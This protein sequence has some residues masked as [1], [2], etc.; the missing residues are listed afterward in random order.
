[1]RHDA[2][3]DSRQQLLMHGLA[4]WRDQYNPLRGLD[5]S[6]AVALLETQNR[7]D[8]TDLMWTYEHIEQTDP[9]LMAL[10]E[11]RLAAI[12]EMDYDIRIASEE[13]HGSAFDA[14][15][16]EDQQ[17]TL[18]AAYERIDNL[19]EA[20]VHMATATFRKLAFAQLHMEGTGRHAQLAHIECLDAW[21]FARQGRNGPFHWNPEA[22]Q[23]AALSLGD[24]LDAERDL[25]IIRE[26]PRPVDRYGLIKFLRAN[27]AEKDW[28][29]FV[30]IYGFNQTFVILPPN[31]PD[32][33]LAEY[34]A[35]AERAADG[36][37]GAV[38]HG[39]EVKFANGERGEQPFRPRLEWLQQQLILAGTGGLL[40]ML[41]A[42]GSGTLAGN[43][44]ADT[45][46][47]LARSEARQISERFQRSIDRLVL[48]LA[49]PGRPRLAYF[50]LA[51]NEE[52]AVGE[53]VDHAVK[54]ATAFPGLTMDPD[55]FA[56]KTGYRLAPALAAPAPSLMHR[57]ADASPV[58]LSGTP[59]AAPVQR[60]AQAAAEALRAS[61]LEA[62]HEAS[63]QDLRPLA[64]LLYAILDIADDEDMYAAV[65]SLRDELPAL[66]DELLPHPELADAF[67]RMLG[68]AVVNGAVE[69]HVASTGHT[70]TGEVPA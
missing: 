4:S 37:S 65:S 54:I 27:L 52:Q 6:R 61:A 24:P 59:G 60:A 55:E 46:R 7:G 12:G 25:L 31:V 38:P 63:M 1:M 42:P 68:A 18:A 50:A 40:T 32:D 28:D 66:A 20:I 53:V 57:A 41:A 49:F 19:A 33:K 30:E 16:A 35:G 9:D 56:E 14:A 5:M 29:G 15:L 17:A 47:T 58:Q 51:A 10:V 3:P 44:H 45:F 26:V 39:S 62:A 2:R 34:L 43:A 23:T 8:F 22:R 36:G 21:N 48:D 70:A 11:R 13:K 67:E 64:D 69:Q